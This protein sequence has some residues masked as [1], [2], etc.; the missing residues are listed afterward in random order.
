VYNVEDYYSTLGLDSGASEESIKLAYRRLAREH[1]PD[2][3]VDSTELERERFSSHM[4]QLNEA[5]AV[6]SNAKLRREY[7]QKLR[8]LGS[9]QTGSTVPR[10]TETPCKPKSKER[11]APHY[12]VDL[13]LALAFSKQLRANLIARHKSLSWKEKNLEGFDWG[14]AGSSWSSHYCVAGRGFGVLNLASAKKFTNYSEAIIARWNRP[15][16]KSHFLFLL[17]FQRL[18]EWESVSAEFNRFF[19]AESHAQFSNVPVE[20]VLLDARQ[21]QTMRFGCRVREKRLEEL[22]QCVSASS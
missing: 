14:L 7:D 9:L 6:L 19:S 18:F 15:I 20:I 21:G 12:D 3:K 8:I 5:Y 16:R 17:P 1:H 10:V 4:V 13:M 2:G 11:V 22:L